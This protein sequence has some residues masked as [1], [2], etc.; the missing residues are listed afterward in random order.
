[1]FE[2]IIRFAIEHRWLVLL[3]VFAI[4]GLGAYSYTRLPIDAVPDIT[5]V[6]VQINTAA[7]GYSPLEAEQRIT[8]PVETAMAGL[9]RMV[10]TR[11]L[12]RYGLSQVT[13]VFEEGTDIYFARQLISERLAQARESLPE[14]I[15]PEMGPISTGL[16]EIFMWTVE[17]DEGAKKPDGSPYTPTDLREIQDW[18]IKPQLRNVRGV[19]EINSIGGFSKEYLVAPDPAKL[20]SFGLG[21]SDL[22]AAIERNNGNVGAGYI[23]KSGEQYLVRAPGQVASTEDIANIVVKAVDGSP[24]C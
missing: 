20:S 15:T 6:Q 19:A 24:I 16:G 4:G 11:S 14:S 2:R 23:E 13:V 18:I 1:M 5:N 3:A 10:Q 17:A 7:S 9:P 8:F 21:L 22:V 12:S